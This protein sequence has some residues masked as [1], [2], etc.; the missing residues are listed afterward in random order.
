MKPLK[1]ITLVVLAL[2][3]FSLSIAQDNPE[4]ISFQTKVSKKKLGINERLRVDF[5]M[6][7]DGD[8][9]ETPSF[10][11]FTVIAGPHTAISNNWVNGKHSYSKTLTFI[12]APQKRG[13]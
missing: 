4:A 11:N 5:T 8:N 13:K 9:F 1:N 10:E 6:N 12:L 7:K 2:F 3:S